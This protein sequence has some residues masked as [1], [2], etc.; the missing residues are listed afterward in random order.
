MF[1]F[2]SKKTNRISADL[3][4]IGY[5]DLVDEK[6]IC[7]GKNVYIQKTN[8]TTIVKIITIWNKI[9]H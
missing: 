7:G 1:V 2:I 6:N 3:R 8:Y 4:D 5:D 9:K